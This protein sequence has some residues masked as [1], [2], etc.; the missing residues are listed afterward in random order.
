[1]QHCL[2]L[3]FFLSCNNGIEELDKRNHFLSSLANLGK[4][5]F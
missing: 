1:M 2:S 4:Y 5:F 3:Y